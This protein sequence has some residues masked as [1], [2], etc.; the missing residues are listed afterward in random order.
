MIC[1]TTAC[2]PCIP[3]DEHHDAS[4]FELLG[5]VPKD[6]N[7]TYSRLEDSSLKELD[8]ELFEHSC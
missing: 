4:E 5:T 6:V 7:F 1:T 8:L 2:S 3:A